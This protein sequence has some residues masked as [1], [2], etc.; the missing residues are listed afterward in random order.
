MNPAQKFLI[1]SVK[2]YQKILSPDH[3][4]WAKNRV[5]FCKYFPTCSEYMIEAVE[6]KGAIIGFGKG[7]WRICRCNPWS[8]GGFDPVEPISKKPS[9]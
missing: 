3:S 4:F 9:K 8:K 5:P 2:T 6:K 7:I 1:A